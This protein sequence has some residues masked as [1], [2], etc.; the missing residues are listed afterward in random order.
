MCGVEKY[1]DNKVDVNCSVT[2]L[3]KGRFDA[4]G[5]GLALVV[6]IVEDIAAVETDE[7]T[8]EGVTVVVGTVVG[9]GD[10]LALVM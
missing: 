7:G 5:K 6:G 2:T 3:E 4:V 8:C 10:G 1:V 9:T